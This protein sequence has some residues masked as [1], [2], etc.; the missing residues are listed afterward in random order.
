VL[1]LA[2]SGLVVAAIAD[3]L[4]LSDRRVKQL[5]SGTCERQGR[6]WLNQAAKNAAPVAAQA[7][8]HPVLAE[9]LTA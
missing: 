8:G 1:A 2:A 6:N 3:R 4:N 5:L 7:D 9:A